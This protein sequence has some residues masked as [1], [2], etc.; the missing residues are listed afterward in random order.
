MTRLCSM[1]VPT[2]VLKYL[3]VVSGADSHI[4]MQKR[5]CRSKVIGRSRLVGG[6]GRFFV[7]DPAVEQVRC[8]AGRSI[9]PSGRAD[10]LEVQCDSCSN[11]C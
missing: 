4:W 3:S 2:S 7:V 10:V 8:L 6:R 11:P 5:N 9:D 1:F